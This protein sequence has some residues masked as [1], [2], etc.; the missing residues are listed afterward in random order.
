[1]KVINLF[2][3]PGSGKSVTAAM[4]FAHL[5]IAGHNAELVHEYAKWLLYADRLEKMME[6]QEYIYAKQHAMLHNL[7]DKVDWVI[8][9][10]PIIL[11]AVYPEVN[12]ILY[13]TKPW[14]ALKE[15]QALV[16]KQFD[17]YSNVNIWLHR[18]E[19]FQDE[20]RLQ[21]EEQSIMID[22]MIRK[23][24]EGRI[25]YEVE[26]G[27]NTLTELLEIVELEDKYIV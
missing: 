6:Q 9:D 7:E 13:E 1:M 2:G 4:L 14:P 23:E 27:T 26:V 18:P 24:M 17:Y 22:E 3:G 16:R 20:G 21:D 11:S 19:T 8:S 10:S 25:H 15:F 12:H 5:K